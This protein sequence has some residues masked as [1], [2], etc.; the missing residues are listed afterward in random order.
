[1]RRPASPVERQVARLEEENSR[2]QQLAAALNRAEANYRELRT[3][4]GVRAPEK[5][6][7]G[8]DRGPRA[9]GR[10]YTPVPR[11]RRCATSRSRGADALA[12]TWL[13]S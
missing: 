6:S 8:P 9:G 13:A 2:V 12:P 5:G 7:G 10:G 3:M 11:R 1:V 4:L